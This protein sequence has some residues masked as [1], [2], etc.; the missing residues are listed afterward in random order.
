[1]L[2]PNSQTLCSKSIQHRYNARSSISSSSRRCIQCLVIAPTR[3]QLNMRAD[4]VELDT[5]IS[6]AV[7]LITT[8]NPSDA[9]TDRTNLRCLATAS[10]ADLLGGGIMSGPWNSE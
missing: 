4:A 8:V 9:G 7:P 10:A 1:M 3:R 6:C 2:A 5:G